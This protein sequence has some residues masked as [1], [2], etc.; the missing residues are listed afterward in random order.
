M[1]IYYTMCSSKKEQNHVICI[2]WMEVE[3]IML[4]QKR[5]DRYRMVSQMWELKI[6]KKVGT[7]VQRQQIRSTYPHNGVGRA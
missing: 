2:K 3:N 5:R 4:S 7:K 1:H 6:H